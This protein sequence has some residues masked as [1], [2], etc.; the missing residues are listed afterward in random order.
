M[1]LLPGWPLQR[2]PVRAEPATPMVQTAWLA[3][4]LWAVHPVQAE[5]VAWVTERKNVLSGV[6]Y[7]LAFGTYLTATAGDRIDRRRYAGASCLFLLA[8]LAKTVTATLPAAVLLVLWWKRGR[9]TRRDVLPL[10][11]FFLAGALLGLNTG[12][13]ERDHVGAQGH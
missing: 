11:P 1:R 6:F 13:L 4:A 3:A 2:P 10:I 12:H 8:L 9:L 7:L 5:S